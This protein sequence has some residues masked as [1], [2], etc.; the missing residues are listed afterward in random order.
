MR[1]AKINKELFK[2]NDNDIFR[3]TGCLSKC[4][5][6]EYVAFPWDTTTSKELG[7][8]MDPNFNQTFNMQIHYTNVEHELRQQVN[9]EC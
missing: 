3:L 4:S 1:Y 5:K 2:A 7:G 8:S 9:S 6:Y